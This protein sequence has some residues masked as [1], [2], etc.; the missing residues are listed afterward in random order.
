MTIQELINQLQEAV[1]GGYPPDTYIR[2]DVFDADDFSI[3][4][5]LVLDA[6][7]SYLP[8]PYLALNV[9]ED[10]ENNNDNTRTD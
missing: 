8:I 1:K 5:N 4:D 9:Y 2:A 3:R 6:D 7:S 10:E